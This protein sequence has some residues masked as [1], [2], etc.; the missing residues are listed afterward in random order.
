VI[1]VDS[2]LERIVP[3]NY[4][5]YCVRNQKDYDGSDHVNAERKQV[6]AFRVHAS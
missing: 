6:S 4:S 3:K 1:A 2:A 5:G